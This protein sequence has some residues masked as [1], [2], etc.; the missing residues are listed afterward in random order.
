MPP[1]SISLPVLL[2]LFALYGITA[3]AA[4]AVS[5]SLLSDLIPY[6]VKGQFF[7]LYSLFERFASILGPAVWGIIVAL[8]TTHGALNYRI[9]ASTMGL[10]V[11]IAVWIAWKLP[12]KTTYANSN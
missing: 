8:V 10:F 3:G 5:R 1:S 11:F 12:E 4:F 9:A 7:S 6:T 2:G